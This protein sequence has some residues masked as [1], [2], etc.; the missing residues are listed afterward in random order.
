MTTFKDLADK[1]K[2]PAEDVGT[3]MGGSFMCGEC[4]EIV[5]EAR[6]YKGT[7]QW[8][9]PEVHETSMVFNV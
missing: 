2:K 9:C 3:P 4:D 8:I 7:L 6:H 5:L 1:N